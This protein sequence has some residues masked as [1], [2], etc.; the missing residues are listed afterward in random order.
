VTLELV[1]PFIAVFAL[2]AMSPGP[3]LAV[4][5]RNTLAG[6]RRQGVLTGLGHGLGFGVYAFLAAIGMAAAIAAS[7]DLVLGLRW[8]GIGLLLYLGAVY[9][10]SALSGG[11]AKKLEHSPTAN[12]RSGFVQGAL[13]AVFN[14][15]ILAW[16]LAIY[17]PFINSDIDT[18]VLLGIAAIGMIIDGSWYT[19]VALFL[20]AGNRA[21]KLQAMS[22]KIDAAMAILMFVF[23]GVLVVEL[24]SAVP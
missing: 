3:S 8:L 17:A 24:L 14:P 20:T 6:G 18:P 19:S 22:R 9:G 15:K 23:V 13:I 11:S 16:M 7:E 1:L 21:E 12:G 5:L 4:V 10:R 2:G